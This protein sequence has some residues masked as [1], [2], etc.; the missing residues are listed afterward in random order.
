MSRR[1]RVRG[2]FNC[3][4]SLRPSRGRRR[5]SQPPRH[6]S[7]SRS[8]PVSRPC[9]WRK[10]IAGRCAIRSFNAGIQRWRDP[11]DGSV[12]FVYMPISAPL[13]P[14]TA[15]G[16]VQY[17]PNQIGSISCIHPTQV[18][19]LWEGAGTPPVPSPREPDQAVA[20]PCVHSPWEMRKPRPEV[21]AGRRSGV[22]SVPVLPAGARPDEGVAVAVLV[23][24]QVGVRSA[25]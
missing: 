16:Y 18:L 13:L 23:I 8:G 1:R 4:N 21:R 24:E 10:S 3:W 14:P 6:R 19:Q 17:G 22:G 9:C 12:C 7:R 11:V 15:E 5:R 2:R 25:R 20:P